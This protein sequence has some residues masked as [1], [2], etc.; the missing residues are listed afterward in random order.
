MRI[1]IIIPAFN[2]EQSIKKVIN[3]IPKDLISEIVVVN[4]NSTDRTETAAR[5]A[6]ATVLFEEY[7]GYGAACLKGI[8]Y[9]SIILDFFQVTIS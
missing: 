8:N 1:S 3:E 5:E 4:N 7:R 6:N 9:L 2:E